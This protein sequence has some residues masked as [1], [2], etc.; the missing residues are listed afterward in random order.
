M[1]AE[2]WL[3]CGVGGVGKTTLAAA[4]AVEAAERGRRVALITVDPARRLADALALPV[5]DTLTALPIDP[6]AGGRLEAVMVEQGAAFER[7]LRGLLGEGERLEALRHNRYFQ[8]VSEKLA[9]APEFMAVDALFGLL[10]S[11]RFDLVVVDTPPAVDALDVFRAPTR[12]RRVLMP[13]GLLRLV[14]P[15]G[16][17]ARWLG[18][19][20]AATLGGLVGARALEDMLAFFALFAEVA[21]S[22]EARGRAVEAALR[23]PGC[24]AWLVV[25][26]DAPERGDP[27]AF[28]GEL[29]A[30]GLHFRGWL[31]NRVDTHPGVTGAPPGWPGGSEALGAALARAAAQEA[32][33]ASAHA[34]LLAR[35]RREGAEARAF[36]RLADAEAGLA[37]L[38]ALTRG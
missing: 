1:S 7:A 37:G 14:R 3:I 22:F 35:L 38:R 31:V 33:S 28:A 2:V 4:L 9:G 30:L 15:A 16:A 21:P 25:D 12:L 36:P 26:A 29:S 18:A 17:W 11:G 13:A 24:G 10:T 8:V 6:S 23:A 19:P 32:R 34:G 5:G 27:Q 20:G